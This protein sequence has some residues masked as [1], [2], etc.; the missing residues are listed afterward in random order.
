MVNFSKNISDDDRMLI[1]S[2]MVFLDYL[3]LT[4]VLLVINNK[5]YL[6]HML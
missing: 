1:A 6:E 2:S 5:M 3:V 4:N